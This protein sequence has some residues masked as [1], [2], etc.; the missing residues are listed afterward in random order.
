[1]KLP[2]PQFEGQTKTKLGNS[3]VKGLVENLLNE[4]LSSFFEEN[5]SIIKSVLSKVID[6]ARAREAARKAR[7]LARRK[8]VLSD[9]SLP[10]KLADCQE[11][12][13]S[14]S[15]I[16]IVE[17]DS[18]GGS[19]KQGRDRR[20][21]AIL[22]LKGKIL[23]VE[24]ARFD[25]MISSEEIRTMIAALGTGIG[26]EEYDID[27]LRY[28]KVIIMTDADVDGS[29]I[30][31]L[32][33]TFF[34][35]QMPELIERGHLY[36]A[37]PPLYRV[38]AGKKERY[39]KDE[40]GFNAFLLKRI[41]QKEKVLLEGGEVISGNRLVR[42]LNGVIK[43][44]ENVKK[45]SRRGYSPRFIEFLVSQGVKNKKQFKN[46]K[47]M[48]N[49]FQRLEENEFGV[50]DIQLSEEGGYYEFLVSEM[51]NGGQTSA[52]N[53]EFFSSPELRELMGLSQEI[54]KVNKGCHI[55]V[56]EA[57]KREIDDPQHL[58][59]ELM[60]GSKK[61]LT[62]QRYKGL[63]EMNPE[64]LWTTTM[65]PEKRTLLRIRIED[66]LEA[67]DIFTVLMGDKVEPRREFIQNN[68][69]EVAELDI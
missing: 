7:E 5:P 28:H 27:S 15:E 17:G 11:R 34:Y 16:F 10:G 22:P 55:Q 51:Q 42:L 1:V 32:L 18:A 58:L 39:I 61:G 33:L 56:G 57:E 6:A 20:F 12:D 23:N 30:R 44:Y 43:F 25:K 63:G 62:I 13:A 53:W 29:H 67:D 54:E 48:E 45:I 59:A 64:Q 38:L 52:V 26:D 9:H 24:K 50:S 65:D 69:L 49:L 46:K 37:Q 40:E 36:V 8:G 35:R 19:A 66:A 68:A 41:S 3:E 14:R 60:E 31:T 21:Q 47:F 2:N 4:G